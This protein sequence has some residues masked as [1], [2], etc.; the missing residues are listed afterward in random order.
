MD[1][2]RFVD[3]RRSGE[4]KLAFSMELRNGFKETSFGI[5][6]TESKKLKQA[7]WSVESISKM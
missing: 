6:D 4:A 5:A 1:V 3:K 7:R 2:I